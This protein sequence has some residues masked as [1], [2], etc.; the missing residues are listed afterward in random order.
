VFN[1]LYTNPQ[2][3]SVWMYVF[4][5]LARCDTTASQRDA[6]AGHCRQLL[7][8]DGENKSK[9]A[10]HA[11][12]KTRQNGPEQKSIVDVL[13]RIDAPRKEYYKIFLK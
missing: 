7:E 10:L 2:D 9:W 12:M 11:M 8:L 5:L 6:L 13:V 3:Q 1:A 4:W